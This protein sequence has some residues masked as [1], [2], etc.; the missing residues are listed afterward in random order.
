[1][2]FQKNQSTLL[3]SPTQTLQCKSYKVVLNALSHAANYKSG[4]T[5]A[6]YNVLYMQGSLNSLE[7][8]F[9]NPNILADFDTIDSML[10]TKATWLT[11]VKL[12]T[13]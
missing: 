6:T 1:M 2:H 4:R 3:S 5:K 8:R 11:N 9:I 10:L 7:I 12:Y 13:T